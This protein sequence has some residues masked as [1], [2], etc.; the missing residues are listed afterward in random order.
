PEQRRAGT[1]AA[2]DEDR[3]IVAGVLSVV[4]RV[5]RV[6]EPLDLH[7]RDAHDLAQADAGGQ[8]DRVRRGHEDIPR[9]DFPPASGQLS[10]IHDPTIGPYFTIRP[11]NTTETIEISL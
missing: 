6:R 11:A 9:R 5:G 3:R 7:A 8:D 1:G 10:P 4:P 2:A